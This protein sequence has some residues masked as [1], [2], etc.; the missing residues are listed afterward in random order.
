V[1][2]RLTHTDLHDAC[3]RPEPD[4]DDRDARSRWSAVLSDLWDAYATSF[5]TAVQEGI[6]Q[7]C[8]DEIADAVDR[9]PR[10][11]SYVVSQHELARARHL[12]ADAALTE[13]AA[14]FMSED[15][16]LA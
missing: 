10:A 7:R 11:V 5:D 1:E 12:G 9:D 2:R 13:A 15:E 16:P 6:D 4:Q 8:R 3:D 14:L